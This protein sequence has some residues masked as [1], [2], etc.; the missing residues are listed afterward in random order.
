MKQFIPSI[1]GGMKSSHPERKQ[2]SLPPK[3][4]G[5]EVI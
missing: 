1:T 4:K 2:L 3:V 5:L